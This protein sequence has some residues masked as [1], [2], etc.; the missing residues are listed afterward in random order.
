MKPPRIAVV[1]CGAMGAATGWRLASRGARVVCFDR[2][3]PPHTLGSSHGESRITRTAYFEGPWYVPL[4]QETFPL[5]R[6]LEA[7]SGADLLTLTGALMIGPPS[8]EP[9]TGALAAA[10]DHGLD[11]RL[12]KADELRQTYPGHIVGNR[13]VAVLDAQA[14]FIRPEAAMAAMIGRVEALGGEVR[15]GVVVSAINHRPD[16]VEVVTDESR[17]TFDAV[18]IAAGPWM[19]EL[20]DWLPLTV[21]RQV[22]AWFALDKKHERADWLTPRRFP[23]FIRQ[24]DDIGDVYGFPTLDGVSVKI[25]RH[26]EGDATDP[27]QVLRDVGDSDLDPLRRYVRTRLRGVTQRVTR[28]VTCMYT[29]TPDRHFA[30]GLHPEDPRVV[31]ISACSGHGF[32]FAP[33][34]GDVAADLACERGTSRDISR[35]SLTRFL[36]RVP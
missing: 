9:V 30:I 21:E 28:T 6:E 33:V 1:G 17:E 2:H 11:V 22:L 10:G 8:S 25:A 29:N 32:K 16:A 35:F 15:R 5:W 7:A 34:I 20:I 18:V 27:H 4:L 13:D 26:H 24:A 31:V 19:H 14:G 12:L 36:K 3:S 23:V